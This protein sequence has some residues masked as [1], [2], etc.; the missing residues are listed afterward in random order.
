MVIESLE[1]AIQRKANI[2]AEITG[3][4]Y[5][6][7]GYSLVRPKSSGKGQKKA[8]EL[9]LKMANWQPLQIDHINT[10]ATSTLAGD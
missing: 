3:Y 8:M 10:H 2:I 7:D 4:G 1:H 5:T 9:S 6:S